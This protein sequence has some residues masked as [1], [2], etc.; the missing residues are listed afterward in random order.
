M[1]RTW[2]GFPATGVPFASNESGDLLIFLP[3]EDNPE[4][5]GSEVYHWNHELRECTCIASSISELIDEA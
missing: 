5:L 3:R 2:P 1:A 4:E